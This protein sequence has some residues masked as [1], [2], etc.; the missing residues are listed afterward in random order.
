MSEQ[1]RCGAT[2]GL[3]R[4]TDNGI[5]SRSICERCYLLQEDERWDELD[6]LWY[7]TARAG[8]RRER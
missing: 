1:C 4:L 2:E 7:G 6:A 3:L 8:G 5:A